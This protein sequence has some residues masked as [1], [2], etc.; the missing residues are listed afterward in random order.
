MLKL[1]PLLFLATACAT[2][3]EK[4]PSSWKQPD[5]LEHNNCGAPIGLFN[6]KGVSNDPDKPAPPLLWLLLNGS[7]EAEKANYI[8]FS[9]IDNGNLLLVAYAG[10]Q[11]I[12]QSREIESTGRNCG[13]RRWQIKTNGESYLG[14]TDMWAAS[15]LWTGGAIIPLADW[16]V[17]TLTQGDDGSLVIEVAEKGSAIITYV[18]PIRFSHDH[19]FRYPSWD[20]EQTEIEP[21]ESN[22]MEAKETEIN[23]SE[24]RQNKVAAKSKK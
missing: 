17:Y 23:V 20:G 19:W 9:Q 6:N 11:Q 15:L 10:R 2:P 7:I 24:G 18:F 8:S 22:E 12:G 4:L 1:L 3:Y 14:R 13:S 21:L 16:I 5:S